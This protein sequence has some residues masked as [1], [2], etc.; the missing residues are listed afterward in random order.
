[1]WPIEDSAVYL[2]QP[3]KGGGMDRVVITVFALA[4]LAAQAAGIF[5]IVYFAAR[6]AIRHERRVSN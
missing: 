3:D 6:L 5:A 4:M 1:V 2:S